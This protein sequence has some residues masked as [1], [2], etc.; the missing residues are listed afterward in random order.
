M[1]GEKLFGAREA[2][3]GAAILEFS[4]ARHGRTV[5]GSSRATVYG[6]SVEL[7]KGE[8]RHHRRKAWHGSTRWINAWT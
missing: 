6:W 2:V 7:E 4:I 5:N 8:G 1:R 3:V